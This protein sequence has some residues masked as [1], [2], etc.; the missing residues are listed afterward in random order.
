M[1]VLGILYLND[2]T[3]YVGQKGEK[4]KKF[5]SIYNGEEL[6]VKTKRETMHQTYCIV[7]K[8][9]NTVIEYLDELNINFISDEILDF[10]SFDDE[11]N[12][13]NRINIIFENL[14]TC[15]NTV[16][17]Y[18]L[19][20]RK[21]WI[22]IGHATI[23]SGTTTTTINNMWLFLISLVFLHVCMVCHAVRV[24]CFERRAFV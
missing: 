11:S 1:K 8:N 17:S 21:F 9:D 14:K 10:Y 12:L 15:S 7:N 16:Q 5:K 23:L 6:L 19:P 4:L 20:I 3:T 24:V 2:K 22:T 18:R 13:S